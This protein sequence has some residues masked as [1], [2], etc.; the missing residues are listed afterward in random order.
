ML[1]K[2]RNKVFPVL[3]GVERTLKIQK[4]RDGTEAVTKAVSSKTSVCFRLSPGDTVGIGRNLL[5]QRNQLFLGS[6]R[7]FQA[8][9]K[10]NHGT[11]FNDCGRF[12]CK[13][14]RS[15]QKVLHEDAYSSVFIKT[16]FLSLKETGN[17]H[18]HKPSPMQAKVATNIL[19]QKVEPVQ[20][21]EDVFREE[22]N[23]I[24]VVTLFRSD[25]FWK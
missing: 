25:E 16:C 10:L 21:L 22:T 13:D 3:G 19:F 14:M 20:T 23:G 7:D 17:K 15:K 18:K 12:A 11:Q 4:K 2:P 9:H 24:V 8:S 1:P 5:T 6:R